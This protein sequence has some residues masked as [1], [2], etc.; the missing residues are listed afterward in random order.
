MRY[1]DAVE[2]EWIQPKRCGYLAMCCDCGLIHELDFRIYRRHIQFRAR[3]NT[4]ATASARRKMKENLVSPRRVRME[5]VS[6]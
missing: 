1:E 3:R 4:R 2:N 6:G 5:G